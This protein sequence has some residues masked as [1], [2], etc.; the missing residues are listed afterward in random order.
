M[1]YGKRDGV[2]P[3]PYLPPPPSTSSPP[4]VDS[5]GLTESDY[6]Q[7]AAVIGCEVAAIKAVAE[8]ESTGRGFLPDGRPTILFEAHVFDRLTGGKHR[9]ARDRRG[10][11]LSVPK[12]DRS[13][14]GASGAHQYER[15]EDAMKLD[16]A[17]AVMAC[18]WGLFQV[19]G[20]NF[21]SLGFPEVRTFKQ[22]LAAMDEAREHL[23]MFVRF[24]MVNQLDDELRRRDWPSF[25]RQYNGPG[26]AQN[27]YDS[28]M[29]AA[30][31]KHAGFA[32]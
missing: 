10:V 18:S 5:L 31:L 15:L 27:K 28:K 9:G 2:A 30:Y 16:E 8:V 26:Y 14:Y 23:D 29:E 13:L 11:A 24:I 19:M 4:P 32:Q 6:R 1:S 12:W 20:F 21:A 25:A 3:P 17:A 22:V 7:A